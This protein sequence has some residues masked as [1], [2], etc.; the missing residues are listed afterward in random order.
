MSEERRNSIGHEPWNHLQT[1]VASEPQTHRLLQVD[2]DFSDVSGVMSATETLVWPANSPP[3]SSQP[4]LCG[5]TGGDYN[6]DDAAEAYNG[7]N[8]ANM[9]YSPD[10]GLV[11]SPQGGTFDIS[12]RTLTGHPFSDFYQNEGSFYNTNDSSYQLFDHHVDKPASYLYNGMESHLNCEAWNYLQELSPHLTG[13]TVSSPNEENTLH[14]YWEEVASCRRDDSLPGYAGT[15]NVQSGVIKIEGNSERFQPEL[16]SSFPPTAGF[17]PEYWSSRVID[18]P[19]NTNEPR[20]RPF[21]WRPASRNSRTNRKL[22]V[23]ATMP[24]L[25]VIHEDGKGGVA[26]STLNTMKG[27]RVGPLSKS[28]AA[29]A[30]KNRKEKCVCIRCKM[31]KQSVSCTNT[32]G[33]LPTHS[34]TVTSR[35]AQGKCLAEVVRKI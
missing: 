11:G 17:F 29:Q 10:S 2:G 5:D 3:E 31:M 15:T 20:S 9:Q 33:F 6:Y 24:T 1:F 30:A 14:N 23:S 35:S 22:S 12:T 21:A 26:L 19:R 4:F 27:R 7:I 8:V 18:E 32:R 28:K 34:L 16:A 13:V 25:S